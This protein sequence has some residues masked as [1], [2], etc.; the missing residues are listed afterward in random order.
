MPQTAQMKQLFFPSV[1]SLLLLSSCEGQTTNLTKSTMNAATQQQRPAAPYE[2][3]GIIDPGINNMIAFALQTPTGW[4]MQQSFTRAWNGSTP[5]NQ[6]YIKLASP[7]GDVIE[8][9]PYTPY[10][11]ADGPMT[12][13][14]RQTAASYGMQQPLQPNEMPPMDALQYI[15]RV[16]LPQLAQRGL[17]FQST[18]ENATP[19]QPKAQN[20][21]TGTAY[22]DGIMANGSKV[23][24][25][26]VVNLTTTQMNGEYYYNWHVLPSIT[27]SKGD[28]NACYAQVAHARRSI[29]YN[30]I[31]EQK[32]AQLVKNGYVANDEITRRNGE[33]SRDYREHVQR[34]GEEIANARNKSQDQINEYFR[35]GIG[36]EA[37]YQDPT[38]GDRVRLA[39]KY[40]HIY[41][42]RQGNYYGTNAAVDHQQFDWTELQRL[43]T[44]QY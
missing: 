25:D 26:C 9:L 43:E 12:R 18:G 3:H 32:N 44:K 38:T 14:M 30:P 7:A 35:D 10:Y 41:K 15:K 37:K 40:N 28:L 24:I 31:W 13:N 11:Y 20:T 36:G 29:V 4:N 2:L 21:S 34:K 17:R 1:I 23:R 22:V 5:I 39:D 6:V 42:D 8:F 27:Q 19:M 16:L 33:M